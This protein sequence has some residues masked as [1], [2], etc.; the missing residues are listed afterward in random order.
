MNKKL[1][2][3]FAI[4]AGLASC[5]DDY[6]DWSSPQSNPEHEAV[7]KF[8]LTVQP[9]VETIDFATETAESIQLF[10][11][12]LESG[13][14]NAFAL[15]LSAEDKAET[16]VLT[17]APDG[18]VV[19]A[20]LQDAVATI[21]GKAPVERILNVKV[22]ADVVITTEDGKIVAKKEAEPFSLK[23]TLDAPQI[24]EHYYL[25]GA[26][27]S[28]E[29]TDISLPF[30]HSGKNVY[31][32]PV[33]TCTFP[34]EDGEIWFAITDDVTLEKRDWAYVFGCAEGNG[35]NG[36]EGKLKRRS[37]LTDDGSW[38]IVVD[39]DAKFVKVTINMME[40][41]YSI[42]KLNFAEYIYEVGNNNGWGEGY[43]L[44][45]PNFDGNYY[46]AMYLVS[47]FKF[48]SNVDNW[49]GSG[50]WGLNSN[51]DE[52]V[53]VNDGM[54]G[55]ISVSADGHYMIEVNLVD[56]TYTL[57]PFTQ[58]GIIGDGQPGG[59]DNDTPLTYDET[60]KCWKAAN[61]QLAAGKSIKFRTVGTWDVV[62]IGGSSL[63]N[64]IFN[65]QDNIPVEKDGTFTVKLYLETQGAPYATL[66][67]E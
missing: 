3:G 62:N 65:S 44:Q 61:V 13:Q 45:G 32:D 37:E 55:N 15:T 8:T 42:E 31:D 35:A 49:E 26:P 27:S 66:T 14:T 33:F 52:G 64:L 1:I 21:Y 25:I 63:S 39:G 34:V 58:L 6:T 11:T 60:E 2:Y 20:E 22:T 53:L 54:S 40:Y 19:S 46:G 43:A 23:I 57:T 30:S 51:N 59:W 48:R 28:W 38:K 5:N 12:N 36:M 17:A 41:S 9:A 47:G 24:S 18:T 4:I 10:S 16:V 50:N 56:M 7:E 67:E 29:I